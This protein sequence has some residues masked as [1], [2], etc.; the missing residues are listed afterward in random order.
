MV[1]VVLAPTGRQREWNKVA[2][3]AMF[4]ICVAYSIVRVCCVMS[5][6]R[7]K[8]RDFILPQLSAEKSWDLGNLNPRLP[9]FSS[10]I[11]VLLLFVISAWKARSMFKTTHTFGVLRV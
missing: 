5:S 1:R 7:C 3:P 9:C 10:G 4:G 2:K 11:R 8:S 6:I